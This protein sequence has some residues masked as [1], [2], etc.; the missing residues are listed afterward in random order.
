M[1]NQYRTCSV[2]GNIEYWEGVEVSVWRDELK[3]GS[4]YII[5]WFQ[6]LQEYRE[7]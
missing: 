7:V 4:T 3:M 2:V 5:V 6:C 1:E